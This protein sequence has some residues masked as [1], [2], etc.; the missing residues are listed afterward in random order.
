MLDADE[1]VPPALWDEIAE[2]I[3]SKNPCAG[4]LI[5]KG[6]HFLGRRFRF[7]GFSHAALLLFQR[8]TASFE[9]L[10]EDPSDALDMEVHERLIVRGRVGKLKTPLIHE[11]FKGLPAYI[12]RH[13]KYSTWDAQMRYHFLQTGRWG[14]ETVQARLFGNTQERRRFLKAVAIRMPFE[15]Q[16][17]FL[18]HYLLRLGFLEARPGYVA[19][20]LR[21][22]YIAQSRAKVHELGLRE[23][24]RPRVLF[25][26]R[27]FHPDVE[28]TGQLLSELC[29][30]LSRSLDVTVVAGRAYN[31]DRFGSWLPVKRERWGQVEILRAYNPRLNKRVFLAR[32]L[33]LS[34]YFCFSFLAGFFARRPDVVIVETDPPVLGLVALFF[35]R[36]YRAKFVFYLQD[37][38]PDV[39][40]AL[41]KLR[42]PLLIHALEAST[43]CILNG[44]DRVV[45]LGDD[46]RQRVLGKGYRHAARIHVIPNWV[47]TTQV[48][49]HSGVN[50][51]REAHQLNGH[52]VVMFSGNLGLSQG[53]EQVLDVAAALAGDKRVRFVFVGE[54]AVKADLMERAKARGLSNTLFL[55]YQPKEFLSVSLSAADLHLVP[56]QKGITGLIVPSKVYGILA[57]GRPFVAA[58]EDDSHAAQI[59]REHGCGI[60][61]EPDSPAELKAAIVWAVDHPAELQEMGRR[62]REASVRIFDRTISVGKFRAMIEELSVGCHKLATRNRRD[63]SS[64]IA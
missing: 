15:P 22:A 48:R 34:S 11:D 54:G 38:Y 32:V 29:Q 25:F 63:A 24:N 47:D 10:V 50:A 20:Q 30:D 45:V 23:A 44:A 4:Y 3:Q 33:N 57:A 39:G 64:Q 13:N 46:M 12:E 7:G 41:G 5:T 53:L 1:C 42:N 62:G 18:Y 17:W 61:V 27:S 19:S 56:L 43:R 35:A 60:R 28:A 26:N 2:A 55:P 52:F 36:L 8:G 58:I 40:V 51:F 59:V 21:A 49:P 16:L 31:M 6:F 14:A 37:L 9:R